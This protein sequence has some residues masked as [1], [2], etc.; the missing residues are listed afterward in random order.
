[1]AISQAVL[2]NAASAMIAA[3]LPKAPL[4]VAMGQTMAIQAKT[5]GIATAGEKG[6]DLVNAA[7]IVREVGQNMA[8]DDPLKVAMEE[9]LA[10]LMGS[11]AAVGKQAADTKLPK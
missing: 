3:M 5:N 11:T 6:I 8:N 9:M 10:S 2:D 4:E 1:M 7:V